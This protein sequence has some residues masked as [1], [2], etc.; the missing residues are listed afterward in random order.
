MIATEADNTGRRMSLTLS[1]NRALGAGGFRL[2]FV[3]LAVVAMAVA[4]FSAFQGNVFAP[5]FAT[6]DLLIVAVAFRAIWRSGDRSERIELHGNTLSVHWDV[7]G[8]SREVARFH[9][10]WVRLT[11][12]DDIPGERCRLVLRSHGKA[13]EIGRWLGAQERIE[14]AKLLQAALMLVQS[15]SRRDTTD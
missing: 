1:P 12:P 4:V 5:L 7:H 11:T 10:Y 13:F 9:P 14:A 15:N 3:L 8:H 2:V 6:I